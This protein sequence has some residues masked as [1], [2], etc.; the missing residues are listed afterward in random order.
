VAEPKVQEIAAPALAGSQ[1][2][3]LTRTADGR[4]LASWVEVQGAQHTL[5]FAIRDKGNWLPTQTVTTH[6][7]KL[8][9]TPVIVPLTDGALAAAWMPSVKNPNNPYAADIFLTRSTDQGKT[10]STASKP[11]TASAQIYD[12][13]MSLAPLTGGKLALVWTDTRAVNFP[14]PGAA[15]E[16]ENGRFQLMSTVIDVQGQAGQG[17]VLDNDVCSCCRAY[18][19]ARGDELL[20]V[21]RDHLPGEVRDIASVRWNVKGQIRPTPIPGDHWVLNGCPANGPAVA[22]RASRAVAAWFTAVD[23]KGRVKLSFSTDKGAHFGKPIEVDDSA[24]GYVHTEMLDDGSAML[25]WRGRS[26]PEEELRIARVT[27]RGEIEDRATVVT[28]GLAQWPSSHPS[29]AQVGK[30]IFVAWTDAQQKRVRM[31]AVTV[32]VAAK[33]DKLARR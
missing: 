4:L 10:W 24:T 23:G 19:A 13:Q 6:A 29:L 33:A 7:G 11:Y 16:Q 8:A 5:R 18:T 32:G 17:R 27:P 26:G 28:G 15:S 1:Q 30:E 3:H 22:M 9:A 31:A 12:A 21:Y 14:P 2:H 20:T 25:A